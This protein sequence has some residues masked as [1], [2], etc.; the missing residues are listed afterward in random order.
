MD[1]ENLIVHLQ[2]QLRLLAEAVLEAHVEDYWDY[3]DECNRSIPCQC[4][5]YQLAREIVKVEK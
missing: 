5:R 4:E 1:E 3:S 2:S